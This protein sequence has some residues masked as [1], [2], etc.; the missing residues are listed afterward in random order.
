M[1]LLII[2]LFFAS[3]S[4][5]AHAQHM[6]DGTLVFSSKRGPI[7]RIAQR[8]TGGDQ[9]THVGVVI[10][11]YVYESDWPRSKRT[12]VAQYGKA[13]TTNDY[14]TPAQPLS[15]QTIDAMRAQANATLGQPYRLRGY[16]NPARTHAD[17]TWC[18]PYAGRVL[19]A[20]GVQLST[21]DYH[22]PQNLLGRVRDQYRFSNRV[23]R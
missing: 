3:T 16:F 19:Q 21:S 10:D 13:R 14:Y 5:I 2:I 9:Y 6:P 17:G 12:P 11:G 4:A 7:G 20:G 23:R 8:I 22:E 15:P 18:S 1:R